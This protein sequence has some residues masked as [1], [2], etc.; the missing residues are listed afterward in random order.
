MIGVA[1]GLVGAFGLS[2]LMTTM[3]FGVQPTDPPT[4]VGVATLLTSVALVACYVRR[5]A[6]RKSIHWWRCAM[7][8]T[9]FSL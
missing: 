9:D 3:L 8:S 5:A 1:C 4:F 6:Q 2:R 7:S